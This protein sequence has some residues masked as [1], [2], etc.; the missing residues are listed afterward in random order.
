MDPIEYSL[1][2]DLTIRHFGSGV[3]DCFGSSHGHDLTAAVNIVSRV[4]LFVGW[5]EPGNCCWHEVLTPSLAVNYC[6]YAA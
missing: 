2:V 1:F 4:D 5:D 3:T 6:L